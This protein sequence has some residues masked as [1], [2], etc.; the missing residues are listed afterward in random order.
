MATELDRKL[1]RIMDTLTGAGQ[2]FETMPFERFGRELPA[3]RNA[4]PSLAHYFAHYCAE[5]AEKPFLVDGEMRLTFAEAYSAAQCVA[6]GLLADHDIERGERVAIAARNSASWIIAYMGITMAGGCAT[7][8][9]GFW[10]GEEL[11]YGIRLAEC[12]LVLA[13]P[14]RIE[15]LEGQDHGARI[16]PMSRAR[17]KEM[18]GKRPRASRVPMAIVSGSPMTSSRPTSGESISSRLMRMVEAALKS[19]SARVTSASRLS[20]TPTGSSSVMKPRPAPPMMAPMT[21]NEKA[22]ETE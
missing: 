4:P 2:P 7:L 13:D 6:R 10:T 12:R 16:V 9:N 14:R 11:A 20:E 18:P 17:P 19:T 21:R 15:R 8:L 5:H 1:D 3:F 22:A